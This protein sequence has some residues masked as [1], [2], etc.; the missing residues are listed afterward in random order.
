MDS[1]EIKALISLLDDTDNEV[2]SV[3][4]SNLMQRGPE[5][6]PELEK[7]W[8]STLNELV[9]E[10]LENVIHNIQ[11]NHTRDNLSRWRKSGAEYILEGAFFVA[12]YQFPEINFNK[13]DK[14]IENIRKDVWLEINNNLTALEKVKILNYIIYEVHKYSK[15]GSNFYSPQ[16]SYINQVIET[17]KGN[18]ISLAIIYLSVAH[19]L[20]LPIYGVNLP[21]NFILAYKDEYRFQDSPDEQDDILFYINPFNKGAVLGKREIDYFVAQQDL[22]PDKSYYIPCSN[23]DVIIRLINN[24]ILS[25]ERIGF[26]DK[27]GKLNELLEVL[28]N[29][30]YL[31]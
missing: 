11:F 14:E 26:H 16:N 30:T 1:N 23:E 29:P 31:A 6:I 17:K 7:A 27:I 12:Q 4:S 9:Q 21:K 15:N 24:L 2:I 5:A 13:I 20:G 25:Y 10:R 22:K 28:N 3:V 18:P 19:K 8:E